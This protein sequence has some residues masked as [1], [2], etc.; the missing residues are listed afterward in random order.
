MI[1]FQCSRYEN[2]SPPSTTASA[3]NGAGSCQER[4]ERTERNNGSTNETNE[5]DKEERESSDVRITSEGSSQS[6]AP[7]VSFMLKF[8]N[9]YIPFSVV[10]WFS[11]HSVFIHFS[12]TLFEACI[13]CL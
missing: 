4:A 11:S 8:Y 2:H 7:K 9:L 12:S 13:L 1:Y 10:S 5:D 6:F 3:G